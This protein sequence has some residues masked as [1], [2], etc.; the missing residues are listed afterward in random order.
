MS[1]RT[2]IRYPAS[3]KKRLLA[4]FPAEGQSEFVRFFSIKDGQRHEPWLMET[5]A[6]SM[7]CFTGAPR[8]RAPIRPIMTDENEGALRLIIA[9][10]QDLHAKAAAPKKP[11]PTRRAPDDL[12]S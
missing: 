9:D 10:L 2:T 3:F 6:D 8:S 5:L 12:R 1:V 7:T 11:L 4:L